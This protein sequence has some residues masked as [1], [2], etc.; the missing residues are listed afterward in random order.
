M[1]E[2]VLGH[3]RVPALAQQTALMHFEST[4]MVIGTT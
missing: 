1:R 4:N 3:Q 2:S